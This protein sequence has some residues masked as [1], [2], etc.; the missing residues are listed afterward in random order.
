MCVSPFTEWIEPTRIATDGVFLGKSKEIIRVFPVRFASLNAFGSSPVQKIVDRIAGHLDADDILNDTLYNRPPFILPFAFCKRSAF[1]RQI[2]NQIDVDCSHLT[3]FVQKLP[4]VSMLTLPAA[5]LEIRI[6]YP[7]KPDYSLGNLFDQ[8]MCFPRC[9]RQP[10]S[11]HHI[12]HKYFRLRV[13]ESD[14]MVIFRPVVADRSGNII[15]L[16]RAVHRANRRKRTF[17]QFILRKHFN[18]IGCIG[19]ENL[20]NTFIIKQENRVF[21]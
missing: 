18:Q 20:V 13:S 5:R 4:Y 6:R 16:A 15:V 17:A 9:L 14:L 19:F 12:L 7:G 3:I 21:A 1:D 2:A 10:A 11:G 8:C